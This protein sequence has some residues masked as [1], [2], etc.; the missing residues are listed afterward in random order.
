MKQRALEAAEAKEKRA[1]R[2]KR[3]EEEIQRKKLEKEMALKK[4]LPRVK[5]DEKDTRTWE[6]IQKDI[7][8]KRKERSEQRKQA[9]AASS[10]YPTS[11]TSASIDKWK[12]RTHAEPE[13]PPPAK[14]AVI[15]QSPAEIAEK[16]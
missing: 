8:E 3:C 13:A 1:Q 10:S 6:E 12:T 5:P 11:A 4:K 7:Q 16:L 15:T 14:P 9:L 2:E